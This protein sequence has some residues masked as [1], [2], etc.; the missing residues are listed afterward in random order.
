MG[1][2]NLNQLNQASS[3]KKKYLHLSFSGKPRSVWEGEGEEPRISQT[4]VS[5]METSMKS[6][7]HDNPLIL[8][9]P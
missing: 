1:Y 8:P 5:Q 9:L 6:Y 2:V 4:W 3:S 7:D